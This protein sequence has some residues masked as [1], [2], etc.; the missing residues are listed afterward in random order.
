MLK[1]NKGKLIISSIITILPILFGLIFWDKLPETMTTHWGAD[2]VADGH[3]GKLFSVV[4]LPLIMLALHLLIIVLMNLDKNKEKA[5]KLFGVMMWVIPAV[6][7]LANGIMYAVAFDAEPR[8]EMLFIPFLGLLFVVMGN[9]MPKC[10]Q[11]NTMGIK[12]KWT[13]E[14]EEN[15]NATHRFA[16][17]VW[18]IGGLMVMAGVF[19]PTKMAV[20]VM[21]ISIFVLVI[22]PII[23]SGLYHRK[24]VREG[25]EFTPVE[26]SKGMK[27]ASIASM[28][29]VPI[30]LVL[31]GVFMFSGD[32]DMV[33]GEK[34]FTI[35]ADF[36]SDLTVEYDAVD[37]IEYLDDH[38]AGV[39]TMG[40]GSARLQAGTFRSDELGSYTRYAYVGCRACVV[41]TVDGKTLVITG[42]DAQ[43]TKAIYD[44][45]SAEIQP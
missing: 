25:A 39:R 15:W 14:N 32:I 8:F 20:S 7:L 30:I 23:Y 42:R 21:V 26:M 5:P 33:Y 37:S 40:L 19:L 28:I 44:R 4:G 18:V 3:S 43:G 34:S 6:S 9:Y 38:D 10:R 17:K 11:N 2:G 22:I 24:Q 12:I 27:G 45:L 41:L 35:D 36:Y 31:V 29:I 1:N 13:L 16:G